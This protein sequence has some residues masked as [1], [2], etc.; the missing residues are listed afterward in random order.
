MPRKT[1]AILAL[2]YFAQGLPFGFQATALPMLLRERGTSLTAI[3][4]AGLLSLPWALK[5]LWAPLVDRFGSRRLGHFRSWILATQALL[6]LTTLGA[7]SLAE[8]PSLAPLL[9]AVLAMNLFAAT[10]DIA[11]D[12]YA[13]RVLSERDLGPANAMQVVGYK[14][15]MLVGGGLLVWLTAARGWSTLFVVMAALMAAV[16]LIALLFARE[17]EAPRER[18]AKTPQRLAAIVA[19]VANALR[20]SG[21]TLIVLVGTYK[22]GEAMIDVMFKPFLRDAGFSAAQVGLW[23]GTYGMVASLLGS[24]AGGAMARKLPLDKALW[25]A[26]ALRVPPLIGEWAV[27]YGQPSAE[28]VIALTLAEHV[29]GGVLTTVMFAYMMSR[30]DRSVG[31]T[32]YTVLASLEV[33]GKSPGAWLSGALADKLG[34]Q[35]VFAL[36]VG[37][38]VAY[39]VFAARMAS[40]TSSRAG[41]ASPPDLGPG[42]G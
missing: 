1:F 12:G 29:C 15:G 3:G 23:L 21:W 34:Y 36:G 39:A 31:A 25:I 19:R 13:L 27:S 22:L 30:T 33:F 14:G 5:A 10:Q 35:P 42:A 16:W 26:A 18:E 20:A 7:A 6:G 17:P 8:R 37:V 32:H 28:A 41:S 40:A 2:L 9:M 11:V 38:S 24:V 4:F